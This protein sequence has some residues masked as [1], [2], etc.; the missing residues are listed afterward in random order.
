MHP[1]CAPFLL[2]G[3]FDS[4]VQFPE[5]AAFIKPGESLRG[6]LGQETQGPWDKVGRN[7]QLQDPENINSTAQPDRNSSPGFEPNLLGPAP[8]KVGALTKPKFPAL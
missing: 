2:T 7:T 8:V 1:K 6:R 4:Q 3:H 5:L